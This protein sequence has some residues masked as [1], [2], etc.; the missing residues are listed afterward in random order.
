MID[1]IASIGI[2]DI[3]LFDL[4][5]SIKQYDGDDPDK[6]R[7]FPINVPIVIHD[8]G[9]YSEICRLDMPGTTSFDWWKDNIRLLA[10]E[11]IHIMALMVG[12]CEDTRLTS[13]MVCQLGHNQT[14]VFTE[15]GLVV[16]GEIIG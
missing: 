16:N 13:N 15:D 2:N 12:Q 3:D 1:Q 8:S 4:H 6:K 10:P 9:F 14:I 7:H 11:M 5:D